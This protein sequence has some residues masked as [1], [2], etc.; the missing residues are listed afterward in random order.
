M[1][2]KEKQSNELFI[3]NEIAMDHTTFYVDVFQ[4]I[5]SPSGAFKLQGFADHFERPYEEKYVN[6]VLEKNSNGKTIISRLEQFEIVITPNMAIQLYNLIGDQLHKL[7]IPTEI[8][9]NVKEEKK[10]E[11]IDTNYR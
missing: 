10:V 9:K 8:Q 6:N 1:A 2:E 5:M 7:G 4:M 11:V 3:R